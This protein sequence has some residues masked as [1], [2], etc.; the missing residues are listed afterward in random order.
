MVF[1]EST[2]V[3]GGAGI[4]RFVFIFASVLLTSGRLTSGET[5]TRPAGD[6]ST[7]GP[8]LVSGEEVAH[9][10]GLPVWGAKEARKYGF[11]LPPPLGASGNVFS[12]KMNFEV[13]EV[14]L[15]PSGGRLLDVDNLVQVTHAKI[16]ETAWTTRFDSWVLPFLSLYGIAGY[17]EGTAGIGVRPAL[18]PTL[19]KS[20]PHFDINLSYDGP[21]VG[22]GGTLAAG[23]K[24]V[25]DRPTI[26]FGLVDLNLTRT[27]LTFSPLV[28]SL[29]PVDV[30]VFSMRLGVRERILR[31]SSLGDVYGSVWG[32]GMYQG[33]QEVMTGRLGIRDLAFRAEAEAVNPWNTIVGGRVEMGENMVLTVEVGIG[34]RDSIMLELTYR[35]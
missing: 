24:P 35:F 32:G 23:F 22:F 33:V 12:S 34:D 21:T 2:Q 4:G 8:E 25:K 3:S 20:S 7:C 11:E 28:E 6:E 5:A 27:F 9:W 13:P 31:T 10:S 19:G 30:M 18:R 29:D 26:V 1:S 15:G 14:K 16:R 17:V